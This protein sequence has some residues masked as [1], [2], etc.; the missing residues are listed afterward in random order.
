[1]TKA[2]QQIFQQVFATFARALV[3]A[4][5]AILALWC[6][7]FWPFTPTG[8][9]AQSRQ[10]EQPEQ[11]YRAEI[12]QWRTRYEERLKAEDGWLALAGLHWLKEGDNWV[13]TIPTST[14]RLGKGPATLGNFRLEQGKVKASFVTAVPVSIVRG[15]SIR[16]AAPQSSR[17]TAERTSEQVSGQTADAFSELHPDSAAGGP[18]I[19]R[20]GDISL[21]VIKRADRFGLRVRDKEQ[22]ERKN[23]KG[24]QWYPIKQRWR[25]QAKFVPYAEPKILP[26]VT[27]IG[28]AEPAP[29]PGY[30]TFSIAGKT[31]RLAA[32]EAGK[33]FF[34]NFK[35]ATNAR[36]SYPAGRFLY[37]DKP[38]AQGTVWLDFNK[39]YSPPCAFTDYATC[40][41]APREN[42]L[43]ASIEAGEKYRS[44]SHSS[45]SSQAASERG[46]EK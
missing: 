2:H 23:F 11:A 6:M 38:D 21:F 40:P 7:T 44:H 12:E 4:G 1:L 36:G 25:V 17:Q 33:R 29:S 15:D 5:A 27:V 13:G 30:V 43:T 10:A 26:I 37:A 14:I 3:R 22:P 16:V 31:Y 9:N 42:H 34:F 8:V 39:A 45:S 24:C 28:D 35:D 20:V 32:Q 18:D 46:D 19:V 41:L